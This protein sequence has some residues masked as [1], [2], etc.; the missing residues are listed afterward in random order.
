L[1]DGAVHPGVAPPRGDLRRVV[2]NA[3]IRAIPPPDPALHA[4]ARSAMLPR[5]WVPA[6]AEEETGM[7]E[8]DPVARNKEV[9]A[10][11]VEEVWNRGNPAAMEDLCHPDLVD[12]SDRFGTALGPGRRAALT[13]QFERA[14]GRPR[15][16]V[17]DLFGER[18]LVAAR[19]TLTGTHQ[20]EWFGVAPAGR[21]VAI[22]GVLIARLREGRIAELWVHYDAEE[23][24]RQLRGEAPHAPPG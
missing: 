17:H 12:H 5:R 9:V 10:R 7:A 14:L 15:V 20:E 8:S 6:R 3:G 11:F 13:A 2:V 23:L 16:A 24:V 21:R 1:F 19:G 18:D 4:P 22:D